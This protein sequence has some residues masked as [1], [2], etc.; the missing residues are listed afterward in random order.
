CPYFVILI[1][2][3]IWLGVEWDNPERGKHDGSNNG[4]QYFQVSSPTGGSFIRPKKADFGVDFLAALRDRY[5]PDDAQTADIDEKELFVRGA[6][7]QITMVEVVG[8]V[9]VAKEQS[10]FASLKDVVL[11]DTKISRIGTT[12]LEKETPGITELDL[13]RNLLSSWQVVSELTSQ[14]RKL[15]G[16]SVS[17]NRLQIPSN[18]SSLASSFSNL[19]ELFINY[20]NLTWPMVAR[21]APMWPSLKNL[22]LCFNRISSI[23]R[24]PPGTFETLELLNL[25]GNELSEW[26]HVMHLSHLPRLDTLILNSNSLTSVLFEDTQAS[27][28]TQHFLSLKS[29]SISDNL[30]SSWRD[31]AELEKLAC[32]AELK[33]RRNPFMKDILAVDVRSQLIARLGGLKN[34]NGSTIVAAER[35]GSEIEYVNK[36]CKEWLASGG[37]RDSKKS[38]PSVEFLQVHPRYLKLIEKYGIPEESELVVKSHTLKDALIAVTIECPDDATKRTLTKKLPRTMELQKLRSLIYKLLKIDVSDQRLTYTSKKV[39]GQELELDNDMRELSFFAIESGDTI[40][41]RW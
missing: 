5:V 7:N 26:Q 31:I 23:D 30:L 8:A 15:K 25:E 3:G 24:L 37:S 35:K 11:R 34:C 16:L 2:S 9:K 22:H 12:Q 6:N 10:T 32:L 41:V 40:L 4:V 20:M 18:P 27:C 29:L 28:K 21:C 39:P 1:S 14:L 38:D 17:E 19:Q 33:I 36:T 13:S